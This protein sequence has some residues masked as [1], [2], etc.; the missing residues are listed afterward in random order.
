MREMC[1]VD[2]ALNQQTPRRSLSRPTEVGFSRFLLNHARS[3]FSSSASEPVMFRHSKASAAAWKIPRSTSSS[4][5]SCFQPVNLATRDFFG[6]LPKSGQCTHRGVC[7][8]VFFR[9]E[10][11][12]RAVIPHDTSPRSRCSSSDF[13]ENGIP[14]NL[15]FLNRPRG[16]YRKRDFARQSGFG[17]YSRTAFLL[18]SYRSLPIVSE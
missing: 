6:H 8:C 7:R 14:G 5:L 11:R 4:A 17:R 1:S 2:S 15:P 13:L 16:K 18:S 10:G 3:S 12:R 9:L